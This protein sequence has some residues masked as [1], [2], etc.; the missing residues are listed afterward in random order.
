MFLIK[1]QRWINVV[2]HN[3][4][5]ADNN[6]LFGTIIYNKIIIYNGTTMVV[7]YKKG[8]TVFQT[9]YPIFIDFM[10]QFYTL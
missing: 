1:W 3:D 2:G 8:C 5:C 9:V 7:L 10:L 6:D 4:R